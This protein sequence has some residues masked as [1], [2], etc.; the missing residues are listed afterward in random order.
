ME[1]KLDTLLLNG[2][3]AALRGAKE[4]GATTFTVV[5]TE[6]AKSDDNTLCQ[7]FD[8][9]SAALSFAFGGAVVGKRAFTIINELPCEELA[10]YSLCG[11]NGALVI[12][13]VENETVKW[14]SRQIFKSAHYPVLEPYDSQSIKRFVKIAFNMSEK[15]DV[16]V[17]VRVSKTL[18]L[19]SG[20]VDIYEP[21]VVKDRLYKKDASKNVLLPSTVALCE[22]DVI[23]RDRRLKKDGETFPIH[24]SA[25]KGSIGVIAVGE[26]ARI[27]EEGL[28]EA[29]ILRLGTSNPLPIQTIKDF[30][31]KVKKIYCIEERP[32]IELELIKNGIKCFG[33]S[34][35]PREGRKS[36]ADIE[37]YIGK[38]DFETDKGLP[39][40]T[41]DFCNDCPLVSL[42]VNIKKSKSIVFTDM[43]CA[44][45]SGGFLGANDVAISD[46]LPS[47]IEFSKKF[48]CVCVIETNSL[49][50]GLESLSLIDESKLCL[51]IIDTNKK[52]DIQSLL[53]AFGLKGDRI[54]L[55]TEEPSLGFDQTPKIYITENV[56]CKYEN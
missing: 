8:T 36:V 39:V 45:L 19:S 16:P 37:G 47:A 51:I 55:K 22:D 21:K 48:P 20:L 53:S 56:D 32:F 26:E 54:N 24:V 9:S 29:S 1:E 18:F 12:L 52:I 43:N 28:P 42:F 50:K 41:A 10:C 30:C 23:E 35:F 25:I 27:A 13:F 15:Y 17:V 14:D 7:V 6:K 38:G 34:I 31:S 11:V 40:R 3:Q 46:P 44:I 5:K 2:Y 49:L 4:A 33:S